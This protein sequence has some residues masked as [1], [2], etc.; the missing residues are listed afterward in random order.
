MA[1]LLT[2]LEHQDKSGVNRRSVQLGREFDRC[3]EELKDIITKEEK[4]NA[5]QN[6]DD[7]K[8]AQV[9]AEDERSESGRSGSDRRY[10]NETERSSA[11][12]GTGTFGT[13][14]DILDSPRR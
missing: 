14:D 3:W 1:S 13:Y 11:V 2:L 4:E 7:A 9:R 10:V 6:T 8:R 12:K 5:R